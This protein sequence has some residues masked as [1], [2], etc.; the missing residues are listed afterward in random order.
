MSEADSGPVPVE[1]RAPKGARM[2]EIAWDDG[3]TTFHTHRV[4]RGFCPC[5]HCQ[6]HVGPIAW[7]G[8][9]DASPESF[10]LVDVQLVGTYALALAWGDGHSTGIYTFPHLRDLA[11]LHGR[12]DMEVRAVTFSR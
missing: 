2:M 9:D 4:L 6:G 11:T 8:S 12:D 3:I 7:A 10:E 5:A 1:V